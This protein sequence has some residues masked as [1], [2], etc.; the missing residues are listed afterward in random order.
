MEQVD[1]P[2]A[3]LVRRAVVP[4]RAR[5][6]PFQGAQALAP[7][8][9]DLDGRAQGLQVGGPAQG[10][11]GGAA[12]RGR[13]VGPAEQVGAFQRQPV[14][15]GPAAALGV[16]A[17]PGD[18]LFL[19]PAVDG[20]QGHGDAQRR[21]RA[22]VLAQVID[23]GDQVGQGGVR[24]ESA[25]VVEQGLDRMQGRVHDRE[26]PVGAQGLVEVDAGLVQAGGVTG[27][28]QGEQGE[29]GRVAG[30]K[31]GPLALSPPQF[32]EIRREQVERGRQSP[33][34]QG[35][36]AAE[37]KRVPA[38]EGGQFIHQPLRLAGAA[39]E[40][41]PQRQVVEQ[42][43]PF[44]RRQGGAQLRPQAEGQGFLV[45]LQRVEGVGEEAADEQGLAPGGQAGA[46][47]RVEGIVDQGDH[48][49]AVGHGWL[50]V[51]AQGVDQQVE[52][53]IFAAH[54]GEAQLPA[55]AVAG[56]GFVATKEG[57]HASRLG[58]G[59]A[60]R[61]NDGLG[62]RHRGRLGGLWRRPFAAPAGGGQRQLRRLDRRGRG[63]Q[64]LGV[65]E[66]GA[67]HHLD[68]LFADP[69]VGADQAGIAQAAQPGGEGGGRFAGGRVVPGKAGPDAE[70]KEHGLVERLVGHGQ[71]LEERPLRRV[72]AL[73]PFEQD[74]ARRFGHGAREGEGISAGGRPP[75]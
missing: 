35:D 48:R 62:E 71:H 19:Q 13:R 42:V 16:A 53:T 29:R 49:V 32:L 9:L 52:I 1:D 38:G 34:D 20:E 18:L 21:E 4:V 40:D 23:K 66:Q 12:G 74:R 5:H 11:D 25:L 15:T 59:A 69:V 8:L 50:A 46:P 60:D 3:G 45:G 37:A 41:E 22:G 10:V 55:G 26:T 33:L 57:V 2:G 70:A 68:D 30:E 14:E 28:Q 63:D 67:D 31:D 7:G 44:V 72:Q 47:G 56:R 64:G 24:G 65:G 54:Q 36:P 51:A 73:P 75:G 43:Q 27:P 61:G 17:E 6:R 58:Q 39:G